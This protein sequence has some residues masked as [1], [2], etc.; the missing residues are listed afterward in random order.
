MEIPLWFGAADRPLFAMA[1]IPADGRVSGAVVLCQP[2]GVEADCSRRTFATL[3]TALADAGLLAIRFD[4]DG[5]GDS[6]GSD[7]DGGRV[8]GWVHAVRQ[9]VGLARQSGASRVALV[10]MRLGATFAASAAD[11]ADGGLGG[12]LLDALVLWDPYVSGR[13]FVRAQRALHLVLFNEGADGDAQQ[14]AS[15]V[16]GDDSVEAPGIVFGAETVAAMRSLDIGSVEGPLAKQVLVLA[17]EVQPQGGKAIERF[18]TERSAERWAT[19]GQELLVDVRPDFAQVP[20]LDVEA[21]TAWL[22]DV[23]AGERTEVTLPRRDEA[24]VGAGDSGPVVERIV[25]LGPTGL[26]GIMTETREAGSSGR[27]AGPTMVF[28]NTGIADHTGPVRLWV[29]LSRRWAQQGLRS[30]RVDLS[31]L[32]FS[33]ARPGRPV[34]VATP[35]EAL[36]DLVDVARAVSPDDP[37]N[38]VFVGLCS[39]GYHA[40]EGALALGARGV[41]A[42]NPVLNWKPAEVHAEQVTDERRQAAP[43][44]K[45]WVRALPAHDKLGPLVERMPHP[46]WW[47]LN[48]VAVEQSPARAMRQLVDR[49]VRT[50][51]VSGEIEWRVMWRGERRAYRE[52][53]RRKGFRQVVVPAIDHV[54]LQRD[55]RELVSRIVTEDTLAAYAPGHVS[56]GSEERERL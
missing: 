41:C 35:P 15:P 3:S 18:V 33:R 14:E 24:V 9:A 52:L 11:T 55:A 36:D 53:E 38:V 56:A 30:V 2:L 7:E 28:L 45:R 39:G 21:V 5:T 49:G 17:R 26:F 1:T 48:R 51:I 46:V 6:A 16:V 29:N 31:G 40:I 23:L 8:Q 34:D 50:F 54:L 19:H 22:A 25:S 27:P 44:R 20:V 47:V 43:V 10:G 12:D 37:A 13:A 32:G 42:I 4:Y